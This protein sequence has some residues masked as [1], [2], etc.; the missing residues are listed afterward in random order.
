[1]KPEIPQL[2]ASEGRSCV[3]SPHKASLRGRGRA[4]GMPTAAVSG[5]RLPFW[6]RSWAAF[7]DHGRTSPAG[8][9]SL[10]APD[11]HAGSGDGCGRTRPGLEGRPSP[12]ATDVGSSRCQRPRASPDGAGTAKRRRHPSPR[13]SQPGEHRRT[14]LGL[15][16]NPSFSAPFATDGL[17]NGRYG[18]GKERTAPAT[19]IAAERTFAPSRISY[20]SCE[21]VH[22]RFSAR[23]PT[24]GCGPRRGP[25]ATTAASVSRPNRE[26]SN[27]DNLCSR[28][29]L[30]RVYGDTCPGNG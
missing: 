4:R 10:I 9:S 27:E 20:Q 23:R 30:D 19:G 25:V 22:R 29:V 11:P 17:R 26:I 28:S 21:V 16:R 6:G 8:L 15:R 12:P 3:G 24:L 5:L 14:P 2:P 1:M 18:M 7:G 13:R